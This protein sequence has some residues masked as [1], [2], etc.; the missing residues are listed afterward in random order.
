MVEKVKLQGKMTLLFCY[1]IA[2]CSQ[3]RQDIL[4]AHKEKAE[5][6]ARLPLRQGEEVLFLTL[7]LIQQQQAEL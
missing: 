2:Y 6:G 5:L 4:L 1:L 3:G 7:S